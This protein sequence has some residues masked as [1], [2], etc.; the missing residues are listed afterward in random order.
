MGVW[1]S[2]AEF[3]AALDAAVDSAMENEVKD[4]AKEALQ[5]SAYQNV[6]NYSPR[7]LVS[8][9]GA[10]GG[11]ADLGN[12]TANY[13]GG[14]LTIQDDAPWQQLWGGAVPGGRLAEA[15]ASGSRRYNFHLAGPRPF[16]EEAERMYAGSGQ[17]E[18]DLAAGLR[19][20]GISVF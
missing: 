19:A 17:F 15:L 16:H 13:G 2:V 4:G 7:V 18:A 14:T 3:A 5:E 10:G 12:M 6:Y 1:G 9:R 8:R 20:R 11:I